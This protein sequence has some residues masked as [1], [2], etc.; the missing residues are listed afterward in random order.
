MQG[1]TCDQAA[2]SKIA[3][4]TLFF[5][6]QYLAYYKSFQYLEKTF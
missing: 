1:Q 5:E 6:H 2:N 3:F 4:F